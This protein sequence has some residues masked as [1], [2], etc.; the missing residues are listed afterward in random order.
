MGSRRGA[1]KDLHSVGRESR[2]MSIGFALGVA[3][4]RN[5]S[6]V[7]WKPNFQDPTGPSIQFAA[8]LPSV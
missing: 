2:V 1:D 3:G 4:F 6:E 8:S 5:D 7:V